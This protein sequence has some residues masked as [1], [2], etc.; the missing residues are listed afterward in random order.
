[1]PEGDPRRAA[2]PRD[3]FVPCRG[4]RYVRSPIKFSPERNG[5]GAFYEIA[6][7]NERIPKRFAFEPHRM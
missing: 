7:Y 5:T 3:F 2:A 4:A 1:V 6:A